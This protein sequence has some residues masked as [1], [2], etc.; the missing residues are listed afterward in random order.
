MIIIEPYSPSWVV[1]FGVFGKAL[2][3]ALGGVAL[4]IHHIGSTSVPGMVAKDVI[5]IQLTVEDLNAEIRT[6]L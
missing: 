6:L 4:G 2:R 1:E 3:S 5:D